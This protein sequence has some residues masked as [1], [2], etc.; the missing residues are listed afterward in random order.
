[1]VAVAQ[2][3]TSSLLSFAPWPRACAELRGWERCLRF[4]AG[5]EGPLLKVLGGL[6][7]RTV[8]V[9]FCRSNGRKWHPRCPIRPRLVGS[10][11][12]R[13]TFSTGPSPQNG[14]AAL[15]RAP[16]DFG[17]PLAPEVR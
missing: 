13:S 14:R 10:K 3:P 9:T 5:A 8:F 7:K 16:L 4:Y 12:R 6:Q 17:L 15:H 1:M 2:E 11:R